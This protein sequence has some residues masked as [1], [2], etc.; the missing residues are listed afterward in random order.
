MTAATE[1]EELDSLCHMWRIKFGEGPVLFT[2]APTPKG[3]FGERVYVTDAETFHEWAPLAWRL[4]NAKMIKSVKLDA[5]YAH[6]APKAWVPRGWQL[7]EE[8]NGNR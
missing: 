6:A 7:R 1:E 5:V 4:R 2:T 8:Q 3:T